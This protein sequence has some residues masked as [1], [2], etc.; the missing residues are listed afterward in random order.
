M[1]ERI[2]RAARAGC[3][4]AP[5]PPSSG[6]PTTGWPG[7]SAWRSVARGHDPRD[8]ALLAFGGAGPLHATA[9][10]RELGIPR[11][12]VPPRPGVTN[13]LGCLVADA[14]HDFVRTLN[15]PL[16]WP[17]HGRSAGGGAGAAGRGQ[18]VA[19][20]RDDADRRR[21]AADRRR[22]AVP[23]PDAPDPCR[24]AARARAARRH[25]ADRRRCRSASPRPIIKRFAVRLPEI[26]AMLVNLVTTLI[27]H[28]PALDPRALIAGRQRA[29]ERRRGR[30]SASARSGS[31]G[32][33]RARPGL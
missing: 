11:V 29:A 24:S 14:R 22:H 30:S 21:D 4:S 5:L 28:R 9:L 13:A 16:A 8:F 26:G 15:R 27:G 6:S 17:R 23:R 1:L 19:R 31:T 10:A 2:G 3:R 25:L 7:P 33:L 20:P 32:G 18:D 12:L